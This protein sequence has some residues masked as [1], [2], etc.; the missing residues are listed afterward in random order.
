[1]RHD[2]IVRHPRGAR[3]DRSAPHAAI[4][5]R[6]ARTAAAA[7]YGSSFSADDATDGTEM[8]WL[9]ANCTAWL[10]VVASDCN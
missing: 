8:P 6:A 9:V 5:R 1:M 4:G 7:C 10:S 2:S 3:D